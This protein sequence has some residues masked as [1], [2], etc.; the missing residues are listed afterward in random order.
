MKKTP[1][2]TK[3]YERDRRSDAQKIKEM[4]LSLERAAKDAEFLKRRLAEMNKLATATHE[5]ASRYRMLRRKELVVMDGE[6]KYLQQDD[7][8][9]YCD[10][11]IEDE[12][13]NLWL[14]QMVVPRSVLKQTQ[15]ILQDEFNKTLNEYRTN[16][17]NT[18]SESQEANTKTAGPETGVLRDADGDG[19]RELWRARLPDMP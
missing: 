6:A 17:N 13:S 19:V 1:W 12:R 2:N 14:N 4:Q 5:D 8:D 15:K 10:K 9:A 7:L 3:P 18:R 11:L 16:G